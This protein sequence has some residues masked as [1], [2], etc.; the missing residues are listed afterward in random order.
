MLAPFFQHAHTVPLF[1]A[2][3]VLCLFVI[4]FNPVKSQFKLNQQIQFGESL[5]QTKDVF[6]S[7]P[8]VAP[9]EDVNVMV[10]DDRRGAS[11]L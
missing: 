10:P 11:D 3:F 8:L 1:M 6:L 2:L 5:W 9:A 4:R 7:I